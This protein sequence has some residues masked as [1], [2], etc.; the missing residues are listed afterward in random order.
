MEKR[1]ELKVKTRETLGKKVR[2]L[3]RQGFTPTNLYGPT[4]E[5]IAIH[6]NGAKGFGIWEDADRFTRARP[7]GP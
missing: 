5:S 4:T 6:W 2:F 7:R 3:R 1:E